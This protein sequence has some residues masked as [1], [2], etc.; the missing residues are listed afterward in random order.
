M[1]ALNEVIKTLENAHVQ[2]EKSNGYYVRYD[3][4][5]DLK[6]DVLHYLNEYEE[7]CLSEESKLDWSNNETD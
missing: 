4:D 6:S 1:M 3:D 7:H 2:T 5:D